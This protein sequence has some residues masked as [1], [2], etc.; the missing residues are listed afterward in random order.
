MISNS[1]KVGVMRFGQKPFCIEIIIVYHVI[2]HNVI[3]D[4]RSWNVYENYLSSGSNNVHLN[5]LCPH[6]GCNSMQ[7]ACNHLNSLANQKLVTV[8]EIQEETEHLMFDIYHEQ[9]K[10]VWNED[11]AM[12]REDFKKL[13]KKY[14]MDMVVDSEDYDDFSF[15]SIRLERKWNEQ[16]NK[17]S[18]DL[19]DILASDE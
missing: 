9:A 14:G 12:F 4:S 17:L 8:Q 10:Q 19:T 16:G 5:Y 13:I 2:N 15:T 6:T 7:E 1:Y 18:R 11:I 3:V